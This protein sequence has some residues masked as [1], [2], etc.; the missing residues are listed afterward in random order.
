M[1][2]SVAILGPFFIWL[3]ITF[4]GVVGPVRL[5]NNAASALP[6]VASALVGSGWGKFMDIAVILSVIGTTQ[7]CVVASARISYS[8]GTDRLLPRQLA[9]VHPRYRTPFNSAILFGILTIIVVNLYVLS[10]SLANAFTNVVNAVGLLFTF[11]YLM[12][13]V[14]T[15]WYYRK[16][17]TRSVTDFFLVGVFPIGA[18][19]MLAWIFAKSVVQFQG[20]ALWSLHRHRGRR[21]R[22]DAR[23]LLRL[24]VAVLP[25]APR[26]LRAIR[27]DDTRRLAGTPTS[28][29]G[30]AS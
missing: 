2:I 30:Q 19:I 15:T 22:A 16:I 12:T 9:A 3:F 14:A 6:Y 1:L 24:Q 21:R 18:A 27:D 4:Q 5:G 13:G 8:M 10:S 20:A 17:L 7:A 29:N 26:L 11:F 23:K 28:S 25:P